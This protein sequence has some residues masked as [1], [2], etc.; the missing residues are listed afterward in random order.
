[1]LA[2]LGWII[3][4]LLA[5]FLA[6]ALVPGRQSMGML[7]TI[8]LGLVGSLLGGWVS[9]MLWPQPVDGIHMAGVL[10]STLGA[11]VVLLIVVMFTRRRVERI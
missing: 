5:G 9:S 3:V 1:M 8:C 2:F 6:R 7:A 4:G 10:M 11:I